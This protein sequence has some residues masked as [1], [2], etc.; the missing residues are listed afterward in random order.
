M[1]KTVFIS[2]AL[3]VACLLQAQQTDIRKRFV[4]TSEKE[5]YALCELMIDST[6][7]TKTDCSYLYTHENERFGMSLLYLKRIDNT[8]TLM[9]FVQNCGFSIH[10]NPNYC[11]NGYFPHISY[12]MPV[13]FYARFLDYLGKLRKSKNYYE[14]D[15]SFEPLYSIRDILKEQYESG[16]LSKK[17]SDRALALIEE[18]SL[19]DIKEGDSFSF[20][21]WNFDRYMTD[22]IRKALV[23]AID[24]PFY[25]SDWLDSYMSLQDTACIDT[26]GIPANISP[27]WKKQFTPEELEV[28]EKE[29]PL[30]D[31]LQKF[32]IYERK[33]REKYNGLSA[34]QAYLQ[35]RRDQ[36]NRK[37]YMHINDIAEYAHKKQ[38]EVLIKHLKAFKE[39]HPDYPLKY[40]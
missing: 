22:K 20:I 2:I 39:K 14:K 5:M 32:L 40:F 37:G 36:F 31:R 34:G 4:A 15:Y 16:K 21:L 28:Y 29:L 12:C 10:S 24:N 11:T 30:F 33:G 26:T 23:H 7:R 27:R 18:I 38:D 19:V 17:D 3:S 6:I 25:S 9:M 1:K 8:D 13:A 35:E